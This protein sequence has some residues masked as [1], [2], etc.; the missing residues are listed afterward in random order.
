MHT[1]AQTGIVTFI[2]QIDSPSLNYE[3]GLTDGGDAC[4]RGEQIPI[5][6]QRDPSPYARGFV[7]GFKMAAI[8]VERK[9]ALKQGEK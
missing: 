4:R 7:R 5:K 3:R 6:T 2:P 9:E 8:E 1:N